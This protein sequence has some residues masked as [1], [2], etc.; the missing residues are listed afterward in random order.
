[1]DERIEKAQVK[2]N[3]VE[4]ALNGMLLGDREPTKADFE[5]L[6]I[7]ISKINHDLNEAIEEA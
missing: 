7:M 5:K 3:T 1:M 4:W 2:L 6:L